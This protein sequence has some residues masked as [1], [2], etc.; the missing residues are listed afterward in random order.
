MQHSHCSGN[1][2]VIYKCFTG[3]RMEDNVHDEYNANLYK[4]FYLQV[5]GNRHVQE[6]VPE[7]AKTI[8]RK[9]QSTSICM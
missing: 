6:K 1:Y 3:N 8:I 4:G 2:T 7:D 5:G 9:T